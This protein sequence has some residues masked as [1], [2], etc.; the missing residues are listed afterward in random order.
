M[1]IPFLI[2]GAVFRGLASTGCPFS[3]LSLR[4]FYGQTTLFARLD[5][6]RAASHFGHQSASLALPTKAFQRSLEGFV[7]LNG[8]FQKVAPFFGRTPV[9]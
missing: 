3:L 9:G 4:F 2:G 8:Y 1:L 6:V 5:V 7:V